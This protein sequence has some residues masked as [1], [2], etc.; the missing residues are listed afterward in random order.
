MDSSMEETI[1]FFCRVLFAFFECFEIMQESLKK[2]L[3][4]IVSQTRSC[5]IILR[6]GRYLYDI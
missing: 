6:E 2:I 4:E 1:V 5:L 3:V